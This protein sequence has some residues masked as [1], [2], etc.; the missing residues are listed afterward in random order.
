MDQLSAMR[1]FVRVVEHGSFSQAAN[2][3]RHS[4]SSVTDA[5]MRLEKHLGVRLLNRTTRRVSPTWEGQQ[6]YQQVKLMLAELD[7][8]E[9]AIGDMRL[10]PRGRLTVEIPI[11]LGMAY[12]VPA[13]P[14][15][16]AAYPLLEICVLFT[17]RPT[18]SGTK[19]DLALRLGE[20][21]DS[22][23]IAKKICELRHLA[24]ATPDYLAQ[25]GEPHH[26]NELGRHNCLGFF[27]PEERAPREWLFENGQE[28]V[29]H[30]PVG[31]LQLNSSEAL[32]E[33]ASHGAGIIY[34]PDLL[35]QR[36]IQKGAM[37]AIL[38][39]WDTLH[40][41]L[42]LVQ[43]HKRYSSAKVQVFGEF[44]EKLFARKH[45]SGSA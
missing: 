30:A 44:L 17:P 14:E 29:R 1:V 10:T 39:D 25:H 20:L 3:L 19:A 41:P 13:L 7:S 24:C 23:A 43:P 11:A 35:V 36:A 26:P 31:N 6:Y 4:N 2:L 5:V 33:L 28:S 38:P 34:L 42:Y 12:I 22:D 45:E 21:A 15:F 18:S 9:S 8:L 40:L 16:A 27:S 32:I 37:R